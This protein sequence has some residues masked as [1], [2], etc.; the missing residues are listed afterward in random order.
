MMPKPE[1]K[2]K[3]GGWFAAGPIRGSPH[4]VGVRS[5]A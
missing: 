3:F 4:S 2:E 5:Q 1:N